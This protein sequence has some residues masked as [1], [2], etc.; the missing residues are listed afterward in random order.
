V[1]AL[2]PVQLD[3]YGRI[4]FKKPLLLPAKGRVLRSSKRNGARLRRLHAQ[5]CR[6]AET[7]PKILT[8]PEVAR[9]IEQDLIQA[10]AATLTSAKIRVTGR[11]NAITPESWSDSRKRCPVIEVIRDYVVSGSPK[12]AARQAELRSFRRIKW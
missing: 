8:H 12:R 9:A 7:K 10:L 2:D 6:L 11:A 4:L 5:A 1:I 3:E